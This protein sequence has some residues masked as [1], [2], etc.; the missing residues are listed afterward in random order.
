[1]IMATVLTTNID[2]TFLI[3][4]WR[5][6][7]RLA[8]ALVEFQRPHMLDG[9]HNHVVLQISWLCVRLLLEIRTIISRA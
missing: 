5:A 3:S 7:P 1:M 8:A 9:H 4:P 2:M 6:G